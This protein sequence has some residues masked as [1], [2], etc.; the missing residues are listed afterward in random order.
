M[1]DYLGKEIYCSYF[2]FGY[3]KCINIKVCP[4]G[5]DD[6]DD[7]YDDTDYDG[8]PWDLIDDQ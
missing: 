4:D 6:D 2:D 5:L 3:A 7:D 8:D 1:C